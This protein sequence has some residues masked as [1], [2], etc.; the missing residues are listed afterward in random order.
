MPRQE[1]KLS[2]F[3]PTSQWRKYR[4][5][6]MHYLEPKGVNKSDR[7]AKALAW[8]NWLAKLSDLEYEE[9]HPVANT[10]AMA[11][12]YQALDYQPETPTATT[13]ASTKISDLLSTYLAMKRQEAESG[14]RSIQT[15]REH[16]DKLDD[17]SAFAREVLGIETIDQITALGLDQYRRTQLH[18][19]TLPKKDKNK[20]SPATVKKR[21]ACLKQFLEWCFELEALPALPRNLNR[22]FAR[23]T[24]PEPAPKSFTVKEVKKLLA[25]AKGQ[26]RLYCLLGLNCGFNPTCVASLRHDHIDWETGEIDRPRHKTNGRQRHKLWGET[27]E[28][29]R[30]HATD[31]DDSQEGGG[32]VLLSARGTCLIQERIKSPTE[33]SRSDSVGRQFTRLKVAL[34]M[35][36]DNRGFKVLRSTS[37]ENIKAS[38]GGEI[39]SVFL[40]HTEKATRR[41]YVTPDYETLYEALEALGELYGIK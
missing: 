19:L 24:L 33:T 36:G 11:T 12:D 10:A 14:E 35:A 6:K 8:E 28:A 13:L 27:L 23:V 20:R 37:A 15:Y 16:V 21:L 2:W 29:L 34:K 7:N 25:K 41:H 18:V 26:T 9:R 38:H 32:L 1:I 30:E 22:K 3:K 17:F 4:K 40:A 5:G 31:R 39:A